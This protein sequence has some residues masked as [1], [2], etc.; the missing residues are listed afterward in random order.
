MSQILTDLG[1]GQ[2]AKNDIYVYITNI[3]WFLS[4]LIQFKRGN[5]G[6]Q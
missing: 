1:Y 3:G 2:N 6:H 4:K 5:Y